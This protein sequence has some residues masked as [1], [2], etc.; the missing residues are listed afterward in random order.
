VN[1]RPLMDMDGCAVK[2]MAQVKVMGAFE[3]VLRIANNRLK[4]RNR[5][6]NLFGRASPAGVTQALSHARQVGASTAR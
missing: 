5:I 1:S 2:H 6:I 3:Y 4:K